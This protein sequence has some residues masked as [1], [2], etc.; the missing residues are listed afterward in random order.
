MIVM[1]QLRLVGLCRSMYASVL[2]NDFLQIGTV[3]CNYVFILVY[4]VFIEYGYFCCIHT[5]HYTSFVE[6]C[7]KLYIELIT[8]N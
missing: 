1:L 6:F 5:S 4:S 3:V 8:E 7:W 2:L